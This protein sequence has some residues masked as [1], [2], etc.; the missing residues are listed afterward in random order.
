ML[1]VLHREAV[2][3]KG[4]YV[5]YDLQGRPRTRSPH[6]RAV[7]LYVLHR[8][9]VSFNRLYVVYD[10]WQITA[11]DGFMSSTICGTLPLPMT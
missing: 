2:S 1:Y 6:R 10:L 7:W 5:A 9:A 4:L 3:F 11:A 8:E